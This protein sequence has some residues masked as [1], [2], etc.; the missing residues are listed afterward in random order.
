MQHRLDNISGAWHGQPLSALHLDLDVPSV[1]PHPVRSADD[2]CLRGPV[3]SHQYSR[4]R[5]IRHPEGIAA[6]KVGTTN[7]FVHRYAALDR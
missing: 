4:Q 1:L 7:A 5:R 2:A 3:R 6:Q